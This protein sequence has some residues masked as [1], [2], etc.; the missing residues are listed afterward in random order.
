MGVRIGLDA[1]RERRHVG[2]VQGPGSD[3][4]EKR[5]ERRVWRQRSQSRCLRSKNIDEWQYN[6]N[7]EK[8]FKAR[9]GRW[10]SYGSIWTGGWGSVH[11]VD[12]LGWR[13]QAIG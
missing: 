12:G 1:R 13:Q 11:F 8:E 7:I 6:S 10:R 2:F 3:G 9:R 4:E 5:F